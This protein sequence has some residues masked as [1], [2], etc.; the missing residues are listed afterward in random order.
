M[1]YGVDAALRRD[2]PASA[3]AIARNSAYY[4]CLF[5]DITPMLQYGVQVDYRETDFAVL[6]DNSGWIVYNQ[7]ALRF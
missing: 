3:G 7:F 4:G 6:N 1:G 5:W 2:L